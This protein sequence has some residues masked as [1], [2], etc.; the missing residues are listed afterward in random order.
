MAT[1]ESHT[2]VRHIVLTKEV[3]PA[4][5]HNSARTDVAMIGVEHER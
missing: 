4:N 2:P 1:L 3:H 5:S